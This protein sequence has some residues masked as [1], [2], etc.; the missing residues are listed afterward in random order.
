[1][2]FPVTKGGLSFGLWVIDPSRWPTDVQSSCRNDWDVSRCVTH[3]KAPSSISASHSLCFLWLLPSL[4][5]RQSIGPSSCL[6][7]QL[8]DSHWSWAALVL[9]SPLTWLVM[10]SKCYCWGTDKINPRNI[11]RIPTVCNTVC[12]ESL[13]HGEERRSLEHPQVVDDPSWLVMALVTV[14]TG[15]VASSFNYL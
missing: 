7:A 8:M 6:P 11:S 12:P 10:P 9:P 5:E 14:Y 2:S 15:S 3:E 4:D 1:M 13:G